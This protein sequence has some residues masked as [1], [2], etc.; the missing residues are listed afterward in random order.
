MKEFKGKTAVITGAARGIGFEIAKECARRGMN[1]VL[2]DIDEN[3]LDMTE[4]YIR[5]MGTSTLSVICDVSEYR[6]V[7]ALSIAATDKFNTVDM[8]FNNA[9]VSA[10]GDIVSMPLTDWEFC[11]H[12]D[13]FG[14]FYGVKAFLPIMKAQKSRC[15]IVNTSSA[16]GLF[17]VP[18][19]PA[20]YAAKFGV[21]GL[22]QSL[23]MSL[24]K[25]NENIG[26]TVLCP[27]L[28][29]TEFNTCDERRPEKFRIDWSNPYYSGD[30]YKAGKQATDND[31]S[32]GAPPE[33][34]VKRLFAGI[35]KEQLYVLMVDGTFDNKRLGI[36]MKKKVNVILGEDN[37]DLSVFG[38]FLKHEEAE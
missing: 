10:L 14:P 26:V 28:V 1:V 13:L 37:P 22:S 34:V 17:A 35:E 20:Y 12:I 21:V 31:I 3:Q 4:N 36:Y 38:D 8:L 27:G 33:L 6:Q 24:K 32:K 30:I 25:E 23:Y 11:I 7:E 29:R 16:A 2:A 19:M 9:G 15:H 5:N 18:G